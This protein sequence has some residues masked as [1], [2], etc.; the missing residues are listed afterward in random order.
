MKKDIKYYAPPGVN[1]RQ[2]IVYFIVAAAVSVLFS[3]SYFYSF[4]E[5]LEEVQSGLQEYMPDF[6]EL[7]GGSMIG[8][9]F[10][11]GFM[12]EAIIYLYVYHRLW[13]SNSTYTM[14]RLPKRYEMHRRCLTL[15]LTGMVISVALA[16]LILM[17]YYALYMTCTPPECLTAN[18]WEKLWRRYQ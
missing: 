9:V 18:Q 14:R 12:V 2:G 13:G 16:F 1:I 8:F 15:P 11:V 5:A 4:F 17:I 3:L 7:L 6:V 10:M